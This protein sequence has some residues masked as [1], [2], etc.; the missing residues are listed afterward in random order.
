YAEFHAVS[1]FP[2]SQLT[3][4]LLIVA[5]VINGPYLIGRSEARVPRVPQSSLSI[6]LKRTW[7]DSG[8]TLTTS[9]KSLTI[10]STGCFFCSF[11]RPLLIYIFTSGLCP[12]V[13]C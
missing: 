8:L 13:L 1:L 2:F 5:E 10:L 3:A 6:S 7:S 4:R 12:S 9:S 11:V